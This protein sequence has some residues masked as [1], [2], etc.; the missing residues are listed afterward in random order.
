MYE[1]HIFKISVLVLFTVFVVKIFYCYMLNNILNRVPRENQQYPQ[2]FIWLCL[3]PL[4]GVVFEWIMLPFGIPNAFKKMFATN[5]EAIN[6]ANSLF[7]LA[8]AQLVFTM[9]GIFFIIKPINQL[10][11][12]LGI[13][14][15]IIYW[16]QIVQFDKK[17]LVTKHP[18]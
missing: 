8:I 5:Q 3:I 15:W 18:S 13:V 11:A 6:A 17:Y 2:W 10:S 1:D 7:K 9:L 16:V 4:L 12:I 14:F